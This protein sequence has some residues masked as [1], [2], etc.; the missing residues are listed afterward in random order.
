MIK[1]FASACIEA[2]TEVMWAQ[3]AK[4]EDIQLWSEAIIQARCEGP[5]VQGV[6]AER[7]CE[8]VGNRTIQERWTAWD[9][10]RT[11]QNEGFATAARG[12]VQTDG[13]RRKVSSTTMRV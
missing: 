9:E 11:F 5:I 1:L 12:K 8:Q 13:Y 4:L 7:T 3:L 10:G 6:G 2:P